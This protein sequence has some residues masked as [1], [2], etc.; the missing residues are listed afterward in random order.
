M[1]PMSSISNKHKSN[2]QKAPPTLRKECGNYGTAVATELKNI[3]RHLD[4]I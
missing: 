3:L 2:I 1:L 4:M